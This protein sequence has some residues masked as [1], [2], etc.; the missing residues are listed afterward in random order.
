[1]VSAGIAALA[2]VVAVLA[3]A[4]PASA[5]T[6]YPSNCQRTTPNPWLF[7]CTQ[8]QYYVDYGTSV[9]GVQFILFNVGMN[10]GT[11]DC[12]FGPK[13]D[14]ATI[15]FQQAHALLADGIVG[16]NT[17]TQLQAQLSDGGLT[18]VYGHYWNI[19][20]D[21][22]RFYYQVIS[23]T[24]FVL[25]PYATPVGYRAMTALGTGGQICP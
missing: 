1:V 14:A 25:D 11:P 4:S 24:W 12:D 6:F 17:W 5:N 13:T 3:P 7:T 21:G 19:R 15:R 22:L 10:P 23:N 18:D 9:L 16:P 2:C 20:N 8:G